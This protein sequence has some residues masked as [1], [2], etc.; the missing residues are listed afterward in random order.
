MFLLILALLSSLLGKFTINFCNNFT[1]ICASDLFSPFF[2]FTLGH[3]S[4]KKLLM[5]GSKKNYQNK[6]VRGR[7]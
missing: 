3:G 4:E 7:G 5:A 6:M 2:L 1:I